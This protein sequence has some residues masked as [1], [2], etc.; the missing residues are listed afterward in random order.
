MEISA[1][2]GA[3]QRGRSEQAQDPPGLV[4]KP[5]DGHR[6]PELRS[7]SMPFRVAIQTMTK[8][9]PL[10]IVRPARSSA[11]SVS[12]VLLVSPFG[13]WETCLRQWARPLLSYGGWDRSTAV[14]STLSVTVRCLGSTAWTE[15]K[16]IARRR[17]KSAFRRRITISSG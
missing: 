3:S 8:P 6:F 9:R 10:V 16:G 13:S 14:L 1:S 11:L 17:L 4:A 15:S 2:I 7:S 12:I 5:H